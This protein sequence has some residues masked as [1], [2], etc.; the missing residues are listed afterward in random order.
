MGVVPLR[1]FVIKVTS[2]CD[3]R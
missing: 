2:R 1:Q 3:L